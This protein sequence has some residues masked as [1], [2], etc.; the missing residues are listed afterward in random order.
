[1]T[2]SLEKLGRWWK[3]RDTPSKKKAENLMPTTERDLRERERDGTAWRMD[4]WVSG[5]N[6]SLFIKSN[7]DINSSN[8]QKKFTAGSINR[9]SC[10]RT[11][12]PRK[13][14]LPEFFEGGGKVPVF[15]EGRK[16][17]NRD[18]LE[19]LT[20]DLKIIKI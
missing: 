14:T 11:C 13:T 16:A 5:L 4:H 9:E 19:H 17:T 8:G 2:T 12:Q 15:V 10:R 6:I 20:V 3:A 18:R 1:M 7:Y